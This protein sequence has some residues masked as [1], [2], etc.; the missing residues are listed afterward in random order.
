[1]IYKIVIAIA[2]LIGLFQLFRTKDKDIRIILAVQILAIGLTFAPRIKSTG[3]F[4]FICAAGLVV[5]YGLFKKHLDLKRIALILAIAI[6]VLIAHI[7]HFF[8]WPHT[9]IIGLSMIIPMIA[10]PIYLFGDMDKDKIELGPLTIF[11]IDAAIR[12]FMTIEWMLN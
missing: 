4:L 1:M 6:P 9:G 10:Y 3:F 12:M 8:Q 2:A 7:F 5:A 11:A